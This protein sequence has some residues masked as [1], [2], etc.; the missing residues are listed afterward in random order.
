MEMN[1]AVEAE[2]PC[3]RR[4]AHKLV[5]SHAAAEELVQECVVRGL[6]KQHLWREGSNMRA[7]LCTIL[8]NLYVNEI[9]RIV[10][11]GT[12]VELS[13]V[14]EQL[15]RPPEQEQILAWRDVRRALADLTHGQR[16]AVI[17]IG[18][19]GWSYERTAGFAGVPVGTV[20]SRLSRGRERL[21]MA[22]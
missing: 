20:R 6:S 16:E 11:E 14:D 10:R 22:A 15:A 2:I 12:A 13:E 8:H 21:R 19:D 4:Y 18:L 5:R 1:K 17:R 3:L 7:W 9:R